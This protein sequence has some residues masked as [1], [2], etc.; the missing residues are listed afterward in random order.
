M[1]NQPLTYPI[2]NGTLTVAQGDL[3]AFSGDAVVNA[4]NSSLAGGGGVDGA[5]HR[6]A[7][8]RLL[9]ACQDI[10]RDQGPLPPGRA[11]ITPGYNLPARFVIHTVGPIWRGGGA[12]EAEILRAAYVSSLRLA[13]GSG[14]RT[15]AF[16]AISCG[17][18]GFPIDLAAPIAYAAITAGLKEDLADEVH[19]ILYS[20]QTFKEFATLARATLGE[21]E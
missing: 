13:A 3:T 18:Y 10:V 11:V 21:P 16:P 19:L 20:T 2:G 5:I 7:G 12:R 14:A 1:D 17:A 15:I 9:A 8:P 6:A 4:A